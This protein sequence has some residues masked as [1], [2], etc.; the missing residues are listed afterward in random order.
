M[1]QR[2]V[3]SS[4]ALPSGQMIR[5]RETKLYRRTDR[6]AVQMGPGRLLLC[7]SVD[8]IMAPEV[9]LYAMTRS[10]DACKLYNAR[11]D[12]HAAALR[13]RGLLYT[14]VRYRVMLDSA[15]IYTSPV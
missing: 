13:G 3:P 14:V 4:R 7:G 9:V 5:G 8:D 15:V 1:Q 12:R 11:I 10:T 6:L 2:D